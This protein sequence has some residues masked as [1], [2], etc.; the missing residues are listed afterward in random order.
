MNPFS[1]LKNLSPFHFTSLHFLFFL[2]IFF[3]YPINPSLHFTFVL[4]Y[5]LQKKKRERERGNFSSFGIVRIYIFV[6]CNWVD[7]RWQWYS[8]HLHTNNTQDDTIKYT[9][10][11]CRIK[12]QF[13]ELFCGVIKFCACFS[14]N[15]NI[16]RTTRDKF[17][18]QKAICGEGIRH[19]SGCLKNA[20]ISLLHNGERT[21]LKKSCKCPCSFT[22]FVVEAPTVCTENE[23]EDVL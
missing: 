20:V 3:A 14:Q 7:T 18:K 12:S 10:L 8:T 6:N 17:V 13:A 2:I 22:Y 5:W 19:C 11:A 9:P 4:I 21:F 23:R 16:S 1:A 15:F